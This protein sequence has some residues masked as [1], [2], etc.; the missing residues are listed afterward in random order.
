[1]DEFQIQT[2]TIMDIPA[3]S[4]QTSVPS[5]VP[6]EAQVP[7]P[8]PPPFPPRRAS[9]DQAHLL[10]FDSPF[11]TDSNV[12]VTAYA[13]DMVQRTEKAQNFADVEASSSAGIEPITVC[14]HGGRPCVNLQERCGLEMLLLLIRIRQVL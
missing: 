6:N 7:V 13:T 3:E 8:S 14:E 5:S 9:S 4:A 10:A 1:M 2:K 11:N 12:D